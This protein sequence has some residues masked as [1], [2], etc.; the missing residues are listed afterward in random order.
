MS[1]REK[2]EEINLEKLLNY[3]G[4]FGDE[5]IPVGDN[6]RLDRSGYA[7]PA[8]LFVTGVNGSREL[9]IRTGP[10]KCEVYKIDPKDAVEKILAAGNI[11]GMS[12]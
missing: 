10:R 5:G 6:K 7:T 2:V 11:S 4:E 12:G 1:K 9:R 8:T 3:V